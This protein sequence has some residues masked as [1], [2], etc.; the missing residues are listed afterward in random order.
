[1]GGKRE[2]LNGRQQWEVTMEKLMGGN[3][4]KLNGR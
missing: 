3:G 1:M 4:G 2:Q